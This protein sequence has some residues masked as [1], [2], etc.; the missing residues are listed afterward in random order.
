MSRANADDLDKVPDALADIESALLRAIGLL[1]IEIK[2]GLE[3]A[4]CIRELIAG[5]R[6]RSAAAL[7]WALGLMER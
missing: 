4:N 5:G 3:S 2:P 6:V 7:K 1:S